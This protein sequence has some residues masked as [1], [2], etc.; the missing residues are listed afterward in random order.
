M[1]VCMAHPGFVVAPRP[2]R[3]WRINVTFTSC[4]EV[5]CGEA[6]G[7]T[8]S[9]FDAVGE[10]PHLFVLQADGPLAG[11]QLDGSYPG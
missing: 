3:I 7:A 9:L 2:Y 5:P 4:V 11:E 1:A 6:K 10:H 8:E